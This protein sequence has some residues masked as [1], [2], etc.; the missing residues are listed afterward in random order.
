MKEIKQG[1]VN[2][3]AFWTALSGMIGVIGLAI[4]AISIILA[5]SVLSGGGAIALGV[6]GGVVGGSIGVG[7]VTAAVSIQVLKPFEDELEFQQILKEYEWLTR[8]MPE[9]A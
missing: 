6:I 5:V 1:D 7:G 4:M 2:R 8:A 9:G 3:E